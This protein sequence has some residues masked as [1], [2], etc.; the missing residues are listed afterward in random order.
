MQTKSVL[1]VL[2]VTLLPSTGA[3]DLP[4]S[5][6]DDVRRKCLQVL[7]DGLKGDEFW[8]AMHAAEAMTLAGQQPVV[9]QALRSKVEA[10]KDDQ[11]RCGLLRE[12]V[13][14]GQP[15][16]SSGMMRILSDKQSNGRVHAAESLYKVGWTGSGK[17]I[18]RAF[19]ETDDIRLK[20]MAGAA[21]AKYGQGEE[22][23]AAFEFLRSTLSES[24]DGTVV[25]LS[26]WIL[27]RVGSDEDRAS[28]RSRL[29]DV[30]DALEKAYLEHALAA[31]GDPEGRQALLQ[32]LTS[33]NPQIRTYAAVFAGEAGL[34]E[35]A[36]LL[37]IQL[38]D[39]HSDARIRAAQALIT[40][41]N[42]RNGSR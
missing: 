4:F 18:D 20:L 40:L 2:F 3:A 36:P 24:D 7:S 13:R 8:P 10:E 32:N 16:W 35:A 33:S 11:R 26:A 12:L 23:A 42:P 1:I 39:T 22:Q 5:L 37:T 30:S 9:V 34:V 29:P 38:N 28:I 14:A 31:L 41:S 19:S 17:A 6:D 27:G 21:L 15:E 25:Q